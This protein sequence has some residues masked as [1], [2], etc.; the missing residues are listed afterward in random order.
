MAARVARFAPNRTGKPVTSSAGV[1]RCSSAGVE[2]R[3]SEDAR[4]IVTISSAAGAK[5]AERFAPNRPETAR[6]GTAEIAKTESAADFE[7][8]AKAALPEPERAH[9]L[10]R[11]R[12]EAK[13][14]GLKAG[15][16]GARQ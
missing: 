8:G 10:R 11:H 16:D 3:I 6:S 1:E 13:T 5:N 7:M 12:D 2:G 14:R 15:S 9:I 4:G